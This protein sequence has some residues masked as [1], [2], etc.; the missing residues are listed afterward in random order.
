MCLLLVDS[1][2]VELTLPLF[3][4]RPPRWRG[5]ALKWSPAL[6]TACALG[7]LDYRQQQVLPL[8]H[9]PSAQGR[10]GH[11]SFKRQNP[12]QP[13]ETKMVRWPPESRDGVQTEW[14]VLLFSI[15]YWGMGRGPA[16]ACTK[17]E[18][19]VA[20]EGGG[21]GAGWAPSWVPFTFPEL[22]ACP[23]LPGPCSS[24]CCCVLWTHVENQPWPSWLPGLG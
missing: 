1:G 10:Q 16:G 6:L 13:G 2:L 12:S 7:S 8:P 11:C 20:A 9:L 17:A 3:L 21:M 14:P 15:L 24:Y 18:G 22:A 5:R 23:L 4:H 19:K